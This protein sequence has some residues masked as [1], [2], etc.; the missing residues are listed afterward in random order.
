MH[1]VVG[2]WSKAPATCT[3]PEWCNC[4]WPPR[5]PASEHPK[6]RRHPP[7]DHPGN[8]HRFA[9]GGRGLPRTWRV[10]AHA[11]APP[12]GYRE[13]SLHPVGQLELQRSRTCWARVSRWCSSTPGIRSSYGSCARSKSGSRT[14]Y[15]SLVRTHSPAP[16]R[17][18]FVSAD[19]PAGAAASKSL[20]PTISRATT[21]TTRVTLDL[22]QLQSLLA[23]VQTLTGFGAGAGYTVAVVP[24]VLVSGTVGGQPFSTKFNPALSFQL[25][26]V[27]LVPA[28]GSTRP[29][30]S[31]S[32]FTPSAG[33]TVATAHSVSNTVS[34]A[35]LSVA[36]ASL[37]WV[38]LAGFLIAAV[39]VF[40]AV[41]LKR[42][43]PSDPRALI[44]AEYG[45]V[46]VPITTTIDD[47][48]RPPIDVTNI[49]ALVQLAQCSERLILHHADN[50]TDTYLVDDEGALYR[51][52]VKANSRQRP[53]GAGLTDSPARVSPRSRTAARPGPSER[54]DP[55][56]APDPPEPGPDPP[57]ASD[58]PGSQ[59]A[60]PTRHGRPEP[61]ETP[62]PDSATVDSPPRRNRTAWADAD[63]GCAG[64]NDRRAHGRA[65]CQ[66]HE[67]PEPGNRIAGD[68]R[69][70]T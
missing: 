36:I 68:Q 65:N 55:Q 52:Q 58:P 25:D 57:I 32:G 5:G 27:E 60:D 64:G 46:I 69:E 8:P 67:P 44:Q 56:P 40:L 3:P 15:R 2:H 43:Q 7:D 54:Q 17:S 63:C 21:P 47:P 42:G 41:L 34:V 26:P 19:R 48:A 13:G 35:G 61:P 9:R 31:P 4:I 39:A 59:I 33:G 37:R 14:A 24:Q 18:S 62:E 53:F 10:R 28:G 70:T 22:T 20:H 38:A 12:H 51:Y 6:H 30:A 23:R 45:N 1:V 16:R 66:N 29:G 49:K 50:G 11:S